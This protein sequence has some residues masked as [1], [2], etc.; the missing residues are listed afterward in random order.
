MSCIVQRGVDVTMRGFNF[1]SNI[2]F[3]N[4]CAKWCFLHYLARGTL[5]ARV[6]AQPLNFFFFKGWVLVLVSPLFPISIP[7]FFPTKWGFH[8]LNN[9]H[10]IS[11][12]GGCLFVS[13]PGSRQIPL[14]SQASLCKAGGWV[15]RGY[16][17]QVPAA[18]R[19]LVA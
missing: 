17:T 15:M 6:C 2:Y 12:H 19:G 8:I 10:G 16:E 1:N 13:K 7:F 4:T 9:L 18:F 3:G 5:S 14:F 11:V